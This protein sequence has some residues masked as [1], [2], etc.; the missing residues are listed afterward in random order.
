VGYTST[1]VF[2]VRKG[3]P[4]GIRDWND[5]VKPDIQVITPK[6]RRRESA[7]RRSTRKRA[8]ASR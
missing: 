8:S 2:L 5:L 3:N 7:S 4:K 6:S 1:I